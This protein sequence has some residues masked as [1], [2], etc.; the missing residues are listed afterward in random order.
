MDLG[1]DAALGV[2]CHYR[3]GLLVVEV[4]AV[5]DDSFVVVRAPCFLRPAKQ[6]GNELFVVGRQLKD[7]V[8][9]PVAFGE[10]QIQ[11]VNLGNGPG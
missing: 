10:D 2:L 8:Q 7:D 5:A 3:F 6:A 4:Q 1:D 9:L 11:V